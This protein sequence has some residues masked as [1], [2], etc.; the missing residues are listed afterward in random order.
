MDF[1]KLNG[2]RQLVDL[3]NV[4]SNVTFTSSVITVGSVTIQYLDTTKSPPALDTITPVVAPMTVTTPLARPLTVLDNDLVGFFMDLDLKQSIGVDANGNLN[5]NF[6]P[7][8]DVKALSAD[9]ADAHIDCFEAGVVSVNTTDNTFVIQGPHGRQF[10]VV[11][12]ANTNFD[13]NDAPLSSFNANTI[14]EVSGTLNTVTADILADEVQVLS[15]DHFF[16]DGLNTFVQTTGA[17]VTGLNLYTRAAAA[18]PFRLSA[19]TN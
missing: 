9:D 2:L 15:Q 13:S 7:T 4:P 8:F 6:T 19:W 5:G 18:R 3:N 1:A 16:A 14:V 11:T 10:T 17:Q 12:N